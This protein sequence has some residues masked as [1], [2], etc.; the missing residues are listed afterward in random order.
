MPG[1]STKVMWPD[2][3]RMTSF[4]PAI[5]SCM[6]CDIDGSDSSWSPTRM[7]VGTLMVGSRSVYSTD[8]RL[9]SIT[10]S[11]CEPHISR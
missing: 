2:F 1:W 9:P 4:E 6:V 8:F 5:F 11:P 10:N 3:G 7:S